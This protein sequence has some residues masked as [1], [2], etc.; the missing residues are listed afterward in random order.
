MSHCNNMASTAMFKKAVKCNFALCSLA[1]GAILL[2]SVPA[3][4]QNMSGGVTQVDGVMTAF[5]SAASTWGPKLNGYAQSLFWALATI[6]FVITFFP[7]AIRGSDIGDIFA[8]LVRYILI[9]GF[10]AALLTNSTAWAEDIVNSFSTAAGA[11]IGSTGSVSPST[12]F[13][14]GGTLA[15]TVM[16]TTLKAAGQ[17]AVAGGA[18]GL[19]VGSPIAGAATG[20]ATELIILVISALIIILCFAY[21]V[22]CLAVTIVEQYIVVNASVLFM[23][24][25]GSSYTREYSLSIL[26]YAVS[27]GAKYFMIVL[28]S[29]VVL[30]ASQNWATAFNSST[31]QVSSFTLAGIALICAYLTKT[32]PDTVQS[33]LNGTSTHHGG[34][35]GQMVAVAAAAAV[36]GGTAAAGAGAAGA[37]GEAAGAA[38]GEA[39]GGAS[40]LAKSLSQSIA[41]GGGEMSP[42]TALDGSGSG[43][44][45]SAPASNGPQSSGGASNAPTSTPAPADDLAGIDKLLGQTPGSSNQTDTVDEADAALAEAE[46][47]GEVAAADMAA[48]APPAAANTQTGSKAADSSVLPAKAISS[49]VGAGASGTPAASPQPSSPDLATGAGSGASVS[50]GSHAAISAAGQEPV[51]AANTQTS[52]GDAGISEGQVEADAAQ[53]RIEQQQS[54]AEVAAEIAEGNSAATGSTGASTPASTPANSSAPRPSGGI[55]AGAAGRGAVRGAGLLAALSVPGMESAASLSLGPNTGSGTGP[56]TG[57][58]AGSSEAGRIEAGDGSWAGGSAQPDNAAVQPVSTPEAFTSHPADTGSAG[59]APTASPGSPET[60]TTGGEGA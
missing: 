51:E 43:S 5:Q 8:E 29:G 50:S 15:K 53:S 28:I 23:G 59:T 19:A 48:Q 17:G 39:T 6:Q 27:V 38:A 10:F 4:A 42:M 58:A 40:G 33:V 30:K 47:A 20:A 1:L 11:A 49:G 9:T 60:P 2:T 25:G 3:L 34:H 57:S 14:E 46:V 13:G 52:S 41:K 7:L 35:L 44:G 37:A 36:T 56:S 55:S 21:M 18:A 54:D 45:P 31:S 26:K 22:A 24:F 32:I 16:G 12:L